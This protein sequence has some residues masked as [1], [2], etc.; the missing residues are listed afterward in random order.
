MVNKTGWITFLGKTASC[1]CSPL[2]FGKVT[3]AARLHF[4]QYRLYGIFAAQRPARIE[5]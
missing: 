4:G 5:T 2:R 1:N 3:K